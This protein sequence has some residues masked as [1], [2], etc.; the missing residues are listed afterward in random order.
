MHNRVL[1]KVCDN[2]E[3]SFKIP[4]S[5]Q[6]KYLHF[7]LFYEPNVRSN[8]FAIGTRQQMNRS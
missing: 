5:S 3:K 2:Y 4:S 8:Y 7:K 6:P 1:Q